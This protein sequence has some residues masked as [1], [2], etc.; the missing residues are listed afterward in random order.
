MAHFTKKASDFIF[1]LLSLILLAPI[2]AIVALLIYLEMG[3]PI[4]FHQP[5]PGKNGRIFYFYKFRTMSNAVDTNGQLLSD[6]QRLTALGKFLRQSSLDELPQLLNV[7]KGDM[8]FVGPRPLLVEYLS[9]YTIEQSRRHLV[10]PGITGWAQVNGRNSLSWEEKFGLDVWYVEHW[11]L[12]LDL[13][14]LILTV[15][16]VVKRDGIAHANHVTMEKFQGSSPS[17]K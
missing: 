6:A 4:F 15:V 3:S 13:R 10:Q 11:N 5:R 1:A 7:L 8:S 16:K 17:V 2:I 14:I 12:L 9:R